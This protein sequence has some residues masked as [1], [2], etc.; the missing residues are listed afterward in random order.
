MNNIKVV[1][2]S[3]NSPN[4]MADMLRNDIGS[5]PQ[6]NNM[7]GMQPQGNNNGGMPPQERQPRMMPG[8]GPNNQGSTMPGG[9]NKQVRPQSIDPSKSNKMQAPNF[10][11]LLGKVAQEPKPNDDNFFGNS[12]ITGG[13]P[14]QNNPPG[15]AEGGDGDKWGF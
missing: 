9:M 3:Q 4:P 13:Q 8:Q 5:Q 2:P 1:K 11:T 15:N 7:G 14:Q 6:Q 12:G 10:G